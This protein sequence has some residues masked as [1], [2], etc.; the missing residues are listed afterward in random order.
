MSIHDRVMTPDWVQTDPARRVGYVRSPGSDAQ[1][2]LTASQ[3]RR[4]APL[5][6]ERT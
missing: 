3:A 4:H 1:L 5:P 6:G 2:D